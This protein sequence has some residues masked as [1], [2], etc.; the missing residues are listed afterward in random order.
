MFSNVSNFLGSCAFCFVLIRIY[1]II[2][3]FTNENNLLMNVVDI[4]VRSYS[5]HKRTPPSFVLTGLIWYI[6]DDWY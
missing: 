6:Y 1:L 2:A 4:T 3:S 5:L